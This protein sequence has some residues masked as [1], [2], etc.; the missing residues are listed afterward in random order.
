[1]RATY[2]KSEFDLGGF[3]IPIEGVFH[4]VAV[5]I[6]LVVGDGGG[7]VDINV[8]LAEDFGNEVGFELVFVGP[9]ENL[10]RGGRKIARIFGG[11]AILGRMVDFGGDGFEIAGFLFSDIVVGNDF[12]GKSVPEK[13]FAAIVVSSESLATG[14]DFGDLDHIEII[15]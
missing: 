15:A 8:M 3:V 1:M 5:E 10:P 11:D 2:V 14:N 13:D 6:R 4:F 7:S 12:A 9:V